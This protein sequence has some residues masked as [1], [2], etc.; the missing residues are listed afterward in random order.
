M[1]NPPP[2]LI[3]ILALSVI[4]M[5]ASNPARAQ[6]ADLNGRWTAAV[7]LGELPMNGS[8]KV[9]FSLGYHL[10]ERAW[11]GIA[12]QISDAIHRGS[13]SFN[14]NSLGLQGLT[15]SHE[16]VG[17]RAYL[18]ARLRPSLGLG[19][20]WAS[21]AGHTLFAEGSGWW[22]RGAPDPEVTVHG[23]GATSGFKR[24]V[25]NRLRTHFTRSLFNTYH[26]FQMGVGIT[27]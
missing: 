8:L 7:E 25:Q 18:H 16:E 2:V 3:T 19:Y 1:R 21:A 17:Q 27:R 11:V 24:E 26:M 6:S 15:A 22:L 20:E 12:Y 10:N 23:E 4:A 5:G 9:G 14:A 13:T